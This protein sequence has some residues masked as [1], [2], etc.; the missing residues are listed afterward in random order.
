MRVDDRL[1]LFRV[2]F[3][4]AD[5][6]DAAGAA[7]EMIAAGAQ[8]NAIAG[9]D[10]AVRAPQRRCVRI[11][12][13]QRVACRADLQCALGDAQLN[14]AAATEQVCRESGRAVAYLESYPRLARGECVRDGGLRI[15]RPQAV[16]N[17][18]I[19]NLA[20]EPYVTGLERCGG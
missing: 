11:Q 5:V 7:D 3:E 9:V 18:L 10:E 4:S 17:R 13:A 19:G 6:D 2:H 12:V 8:F 1:D 14:V 20:R 15:H 16:E